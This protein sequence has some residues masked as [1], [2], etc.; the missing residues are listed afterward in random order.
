MRT[1]ADMTEGSVAKITEISG[2]HDMVKRRLQ[3]LGILEGAQIRVARCL[4]FGGPLMIECN[5]QC[6][7]LR[8]CEAPMIRVVRE[9]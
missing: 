6:I 2:V 7:G 4:P 3:D 1:L 8:K 5:G 9:C